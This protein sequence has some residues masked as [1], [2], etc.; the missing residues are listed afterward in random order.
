MWWPRAAALARGA[1]RARRDG[2]GGGGPL[3]RRRGPRRA[4]GPPA[5]ASRPD[6]ARPRGRARRARDPERGTVRVAGADRGR[7]GVRAQRDPRPRYS[8]ALRPLGAG[9][10]PVYFGSARWISRRLARAAAPQASSRAGSPLRRDRPP[11][12][13]LSLA[14]RLAA[15]GGAGG[16]DAGARRD[17]PAA[18]ARR[19]AARPDLP[20]GA[21]RAA[22]GSARAPLG[23]RLALGRGNSRRDLGRPRVRA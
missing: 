3:E 11:A 5:G 16:R 1:R 14:A 22:G 12:R 8:R 13:C 23:R 19:G 17:R 4:R 7:A 18:P 9:A 21:G 15:A 2:V 20:L 10:S 6:T